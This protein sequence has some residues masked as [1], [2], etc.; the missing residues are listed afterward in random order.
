M[1]TA[2]KVTTSDDGLDEAPSPKAENRI[3]ASH[4]A[5]GIAV[6]RAEQ[7]LNSAEDVA[8][9]ANPDR[10]DLQQARM[11]GS[12]QQALQELMSEVKPFAAPTETVEA[13]LALTQKQR[14]SS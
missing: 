5:L 7:C 3:L 8:A 4:M 10:P 6:R 14:P 11:L 2:E 9:S 1:N 13:F 12:Y